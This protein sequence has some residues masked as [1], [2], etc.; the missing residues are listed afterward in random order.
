MARRYF[1]KRYSKRR[2]KRTLSSYQIATKTN[3]KA[4]S[5]QIYALNRKVNY[6]Q[7]MTRPETIIQQRLAYPSLE[8]TTP[9][10]SFSESARGIAPVYWRD[11]LQSDVQSAIIPIIGTKL[12]ATTTKNRFARLHTCS[13]YGNLQYNT[14]STT[15]RPFTLRVVI[16]QT[17]ATRG[18]SIQAADIFSNVSTADESRVVSVFGPLQTG[19]ARTAKVLSDKRYNLSF[20]RPNVTI[21]TTLNYL[22]NFYIDQDND[23]SSTGQSSESIAKGSIFV[24]LAW[25]SLGEPQDVQLSISAK[26]AFT[27]A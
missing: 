6:I 17:R 9:A 27:D 15:V 10:I 20:Q 25:H 11:E 2:G 1:R 5:R 7:R 24:F 18:E 19:L 21:Q 22:M 23:T 12:P 4:Q 8:S 26:L 16:V 3:A 14:P 13:L